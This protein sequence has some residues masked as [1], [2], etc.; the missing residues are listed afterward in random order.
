M[1]PSSQHTADSSPPFTQE[2]IEWLAARDATL[3]ANR[4]SWVIAREERLAKHGTDWSRRHVRSYARRATAAFVI[5]ALGIGGAFYAGGQ[6]S[7]QSRRAIVKSGR[8]VSVSGCNRDY[9]TINR[10]RSVLAR[11][12]DFQRAALNR[13][14]ITQ[15]QY[16][17]AVVYFKEQLMGLP[18]VDCRPS[19]TILTDD[20][21]DIGKVPEPLH[22]PD[23]PYSGPH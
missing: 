15:D 4:E 16:D 3:D 6:D 22:P 23:P 14:D 17:R 19:A 13:G 8:V 20:P 7:T 2:Q 12:L 5:L 10:L 11:S 21:N 18:P 9:I 1:T